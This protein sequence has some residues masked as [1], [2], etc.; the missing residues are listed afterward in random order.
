[1]KAHLVA[2]GVECEAVRLD[3]YTGRR[4]FFCADPDQ[5]PIEFYEA[6]K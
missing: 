4:F 1:M 5:L 3:E 6:R 2:C